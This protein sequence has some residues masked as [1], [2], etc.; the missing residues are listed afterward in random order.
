MQVDAQVPE[1]Y[2]ESGK[3]LPAQA[4]SSRKIERKV[5]PL[6]PRKTGGTTT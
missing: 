2:F 5:L 1:Q 3:N 4:A 6:F